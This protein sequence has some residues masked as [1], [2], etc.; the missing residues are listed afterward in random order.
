V[1][2]EIGSGPDPG[3]EPLVARVAQLE[4]HLAALSERLGKLEEHVAVLGEQASQSQH[5]AE[6]E[7]RRIDNDLRTLGAAVES[8]RKAVAQTDD[9]VERVVEALESLQSAAP[10]PREPGTAGVN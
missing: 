2:S 9:L 7:I 5:R 6:T 1:S 8:S 3:L 10:E 4:Q